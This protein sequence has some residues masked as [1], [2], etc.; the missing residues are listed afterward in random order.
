MIRLPTA[1]LEEVRR[2]LTTTY[3]QFLASYEQPAI[4]SL[5]A[6][7]QKITTQQLQQL[8]PFSVEPVPWCNEGFYY[9][10]AS[11][12]GKHVYHAAGLYY[13]QEAS[14]MAPVEALQ[15]LPGENVLD[16]C[17][18]PGGKTTQIAA[19]LQGKGILVAN[20]VDSKRCKALISNLERLGVSNAVV[21]NEQPQRLS[22]RFTD[23]FDRILVDAPCSGEGM[24][25]K[26]PDACSHWSIKNS[27][28]C[29]DLQQMILTEAAKMLKPGGRLVYSTCTFNTRENEQTL[30]LFLQTHP[31]FSLCTL[32]NHHYFQPGLTEQTVHAGR[33]WPHLLRGE[34]HFV[35]VLEKSKDDEPKRIKPA[36]HQRISKTT[37]AIVE[38]FF[39][40]W[41]LDIEGTIVAYGDHL[42]VTP[43]ALPSLDKC[44]VAQP[45]RYLGEIRKNRF[46]PSHALAMTLEP[47]TAPRVQAYTQHDDE[48]YR[49]LQGE[50]VP[51]TEQ[52]WTLVTVDGYPLGWGKGAAGVLKNHYPKWLRFAYD[53]A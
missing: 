44:K 28:K 27:E 7:T 2:E 26:D 29:A 32:P 25:R 1:F 6:N 16:L 51:T 8:L 23:F 41:Q 18:A 11:R 43:F 10:P 5:R 33:L 47:S 52:G 24:F 53:R 40:E 14:A 19:K 35:A 17:A 31:T 4:K 34:G 42:Y 3:E 30:E 49:F 37:A 39:A 45:G 38:S 46:I 22:A 21:L 48:L 13:I 20:E 50:T 15:P 12:P 36:K 9:S